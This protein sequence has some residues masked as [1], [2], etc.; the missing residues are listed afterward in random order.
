MDSSKWL[1]LQVYLE[2]SQEFYAVETP[3]PGALNQPLLRD[4]IV[5][6]E[7]MFDPSNLVS[8]EFIEL[9]NRGDSAWYL[10]GGA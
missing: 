5:I 4:S 7:I 1:V 8:G 6:H 3:S 10:T 9:Y 2:G